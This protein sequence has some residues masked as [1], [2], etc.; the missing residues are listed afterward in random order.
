[1]TCH[2][3]LQ[4]GDQRRHQSTHRPSAAFAAVNGTH[5]CILCDTHSATKARALRPMVTKFI[6]RRASTTQRLMQ[7][8]N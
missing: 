6:Q 3:R 5:L 4:D 7:M 1:M 2:P 8:V